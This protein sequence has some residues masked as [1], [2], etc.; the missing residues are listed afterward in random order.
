MEIPLSSQPIIARQ[1]A[2]SLRNTYLAFLG[3]QTC[4][5]SPSN[6]YNRGMA[7]SFFYTVLMSFIEE[8]QL[9]LYRIIPVK[10]SVQCW[11][12]NAALV[13]MAGGCSIQSHTVRTAGPCSGRAGLE[14]ILCHLDLGAIAGSWSCGSGIRPIRLARGE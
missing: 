12:G 4:S 9:H 10:P 3:K 5:I 7:S 11:Y 14:V 6:A 8:F 2:Y 13:P 1:L